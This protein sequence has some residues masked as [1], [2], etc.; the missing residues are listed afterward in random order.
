MPKEG[1]IWVSWSNDFLPTIKLLVNFK[2]WNLLSFLRSSTSSESDSSSS[3]S[4]RRH[5]VHWY[6]E[7]VRVCRKA[8][9]KVM[10]LSAQ[11]LSRTKKNFRGQD[12]RSFKMLG[13]NFHKSFLCQAHTHTQW[14]VRVLIP[15]RPVSNLRTSGAPAKASASVAN[16]FERTYWSIAETLPH[17]LN[18]A[19]D[20]QGYSRSRRKELMNFGIVWESVYENGCKFKNICSGHW[21]HLASEYAWLRD[22]LLQTALEA[23]LPSSLRTN[24]KDLVRRYLPPGR[25]TDLFQLY[26]A[27][28]LSQNQPAASARTFWRVLKARMVQ[29]F[30]CMLSET[31][32]L[33]ICLKE[34]DA[35]RLHSCDLGPA[36]RLA[37]SAEISA[38][39]YSLRMSYLS[40]TEEG[41]ERS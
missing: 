24:P 27:F 36:V 40:Q 11:R 32:S 26:Q 34:S 30:C 20:E 23:D 35:N 8:F 10:G 19:P 3:S 41:D 2:R 17:D 38:S 6:I 18:L 25:Y 16:F 15:V 13:F 37:K 33:L 28:Q 1:H 12:M 31:V 21:R 5:Q 7:G 29:R 9:L 14:S 22:G 4:E 39:Q